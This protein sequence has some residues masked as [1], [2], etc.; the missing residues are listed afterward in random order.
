MKRQWITITAFLLA[1]LSLATLGAGC[2]YR[3]AETAQPSTQATEAPEPSGAQTE[4]EEALELQVEGTLLLTTEEATI[5]LTLKDGTLIQDIA[6]Q[7]EMVNIGFGTG[8]T[9][10]TS[11]ERIGDHTMDVTFV[12]T[13]D[14]AVKLESWGTQTQGYVQLSGEA[15]EEGLPA[16]GNLE[17]AYP[18]AMVKETSARGAERLTLTVETENTTFTDAVS[19]EDVTLSDGFSGM[20]VESVERQS[21]NA[22]RVTIAGTMPEADENNIPYMEGAI[23]LGQDATKAGVSLCAESE[24]VTAAAYWGDYPQV[25]ADGNS[26][27][28]RITLENC[29]W[30]Q[31]VAL[32]QFTLQG[33][34]DGLA[35]TSVERVDDANVDVVL[36]ATDEE[37]R[38]PE[39]LSIH[40]AAEATT[41]GR[42]LGVNF[43]LSQQV[44][45]GEA[46]DIAV[47]GESATVTISLDATGFTFKRTPEAGEIALEDAFVNAE[48]ID[49]S[50]ESDT[51]LTMTVSVPVADLTGDYVD[52]GLI[53]LPEDAIEKEGGALEEYDNVVYVSVLLEDS[54]T[55]QTTVSVDG[56]GSSDMMLLSTTTSNSLATGIAKKALNFFCNEAKDKLVSMAKNKVESGVTSIFKTILSVFGFSSDDRSKELK[57]LQEISDQLKDM[58]VQIDS[59]AKDV[60]KL[61]DATETSAFKQQMRDVQSSVLALKPRIT[62]YLG[63]FEALIQLEPGT[64]QYNSELKILADSI[65]NTQ[66]I[67]FHSETYALGEKLLSDAAGT[68]AGALETHYNRIMTQNNWEQQTYDERERFY[69]YTIGTY[70]Q[71]AVFDQLA[72]QYT[73]ETTTSSVTKS[74]AQSRLNELNTQLEKVAALAEKYAIKRLDGKY[75]RNLRAN[76]ILEKNIQSVT[77]NESNRL[78]SDTDAFSLIQHKLDQ[79]ASKWGGRNIAMN[80]SSIFHI[81]GANLLTEEQAN[82]IMKYSSQK[83][84]LEELRTAGFTIPK[85]CASQVILGD[86]KV[87]KWF[88]RTGSSPTRYS[89]TIYYRLYDSKVSEKNTRNFCLNSNTKTQD[90]FNLK[91]Y[92]YTGS[93]YQGHT[94]VNAA[95]VTVVKDSNSLYV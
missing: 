61:I 69:L 25:S 2:V 31:D 10:A 45:L 93:R 74:A 40:I 57:M 47:E 38:D 20:T 37:E 9:I 12:M 95:R 53:V 77:F 80:G 24:L 1:L 67:D 18:S 6:S 43:S 75:D 63:G 50:M 85:N 60:K 76:V 78:V 52:V 86:V 17:I 49:V 71:A 33:D 29:Q 7:P 68:S 91:A 28:L 15:T 13:H 59:I 21:D 19:V 41:A 23:V 58:S 51:Q 22:I 70:Y 30:S 62:G 34:T 56:A 42:E 55:E 14:D 79:G 44:I 87:D 83:S 66:G 3:P 36:A 92:G 65:N 4:D 84:L 5:R 27:R 32:E 35:L 46:T 16:Y 72:L 48:V 94:D 88:I 90:Y 73:I 81:D 39:T 54:Q 11:V 89:Y 26:L 8:D 64:E 82:T